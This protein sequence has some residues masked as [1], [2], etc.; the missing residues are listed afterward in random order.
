MAHRGRLNVLARTSWASRWTKIFAEFEGIDPSRRRV[1]GD[2]KYHLGY[3]PTTPTAAGKQVHLS[4]AFNPSHLEAVDPVVEGRV[5]AKQ[6]RL[7]GG[8]RPQQVMPVVLHGDA[9]FAGQGLVAETLNYVA[10]SPATAPAAPFTWSSTT[11]SASPPRPTTRRSTPYCTDVAQMLAGA[12]L[13]RQRRR[14]RGGRAPRDAPG[15]EYRQKFH[16]RRRHRPVL[17]PQVRPQR[18]R[19]AE[20]HPAEDVRAHSGS[21]AACGRC[22]PIS[23]AA[24]GRVSPPDGVAVY[25][26]CLASWSR[27]AGREF[28]GA[29]G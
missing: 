2:V 22:T 15:V 6:D 18:R 7:G 1:R 23:Y 12:D 26:E 28:E 11:R 25:D 19:R 8:D 4:L 20:L 5:R 10:A 3:S 13:P 21:T 9:A 29:A 24:L 27:D 17:L 16:I 14:P